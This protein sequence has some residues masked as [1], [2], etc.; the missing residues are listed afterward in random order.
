[1]PGWPIL[2]T[3]IF[4]PLI[5]A[6]F[7]LLIRGEDPIAVRNMRGVALWT[8]LI[9]FVLALMMWVE[10]DPSISGFQFEERY[11]WVGGLMSYH[12]GVD[13]ILYDESQHH[14]PSL[15]CFDTA[16]GHRYGVPTYARDREFV[17]LLRNGADLSTEFLWAGE[18]C[19]DW[20]LEEYQL[21]YHRSADSHHIPFI[22]YLRPNT[23]M[24]TVSIIKLLPHR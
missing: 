12:L 3:I 17:R 1:M 13:G 22:R 14:S 24:M 18:A 7:V 8:T 15:L 19:Y 9:T 2:S 11:S 10:F 21:S 6:L 20:E 16:H 4:L 5:G 23:P